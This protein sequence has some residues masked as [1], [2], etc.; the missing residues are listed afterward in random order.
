MEKETGK[1]SWDTDQCVHSLRTGQHA[2]EEVHGSVQ[3]MV[4]TDDGHNDDIT[5]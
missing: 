2:Q 4:N 1:H 5:S 3:M